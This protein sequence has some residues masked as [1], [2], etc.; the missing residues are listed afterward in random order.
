MTMNTELYD[1]RWNKAS[2]LEINV[3]R[4]CVTKM[5]FAVEAVE[6]H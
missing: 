1:V 6:L 2:E 5:D 3:F 4:F